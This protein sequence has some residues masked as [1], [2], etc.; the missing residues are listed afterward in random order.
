MQLTHTELGGNVFFDCEAI[1]A[2]ERYFSV[3]TL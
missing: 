2:I 1:P 3:T